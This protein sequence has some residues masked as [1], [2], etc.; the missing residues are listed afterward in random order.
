MKIISPADEVTLWLGATR[1][2]VGRRT[3]AVNDFCDLLIN[4]WQNL[5]ITTQDLIA[6]DLEIEFIRDDDARINKNKF[7]PLGDDC[8]RESWEK[9][10]NLWIK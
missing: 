8:D 3:Y 1:Y 6:R 2:Y 10:R 5:H 4:N 7:K 9:V